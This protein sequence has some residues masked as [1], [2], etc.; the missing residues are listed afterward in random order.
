MVPAFL[1]CDRVAA[2]FE[3]EIVH[4]ERVLGAA[5]DVAVQENRPGGG[6]GATIESVV[7]PFHVLEIVV[8]SK[9]DIDPDIIAK[10]PVSYSRAFLFEL[11]NLAE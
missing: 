4:D 9:I 10:I 3:K 8:A 6:L 1:C 7:E 5:L 2:T 11:T